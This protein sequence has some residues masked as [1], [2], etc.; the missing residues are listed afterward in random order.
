MPNTQQHAQKDE[1]HEE[2]SDDGATSDASSVLS[3]DAGDAVACIGDTVGDTVA[4]IKKKKKSLRHTAMKGRKGLYVPRN[5]K[6]MALAANIKRQQKDVLM[7]MY[8]DDIQP[9]LEA[10]VKIAIKFAQFSKKKTVSLKHMVRAVM[11]V[12]NCTPAVY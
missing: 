5:L 11:S 9:S 10:I 3:C 12:Y 2:S 6:Q 1:L 4:V 7:L 8:T